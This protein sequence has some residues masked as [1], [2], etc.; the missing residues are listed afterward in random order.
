[1][2]KLSFL[3]ENRLGVPVSLNLRRRLRLGL[4]LIDNVGISLVCL[5]LG[6]LVREVTLLIHPTWSI[7]LWLLVWK[8]RLLERH[9]VIHMIGVGRRS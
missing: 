2:K 1:M 3:I 5:A 7:M 6:R 9:M 4:V 8:T